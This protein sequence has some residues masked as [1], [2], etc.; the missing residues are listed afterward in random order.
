MP[1]L[2]ETFKAPA[3]TPKTGLS[4]LLEA[5]ITSRFWP[6]RLCLHRNLSI[7]VSNHQNCLDCGASRRYSFLTDFEHADAGI[8]IGPW[9]RAAYFY[10]AQDA[11]RVVASNLIDDAI[12]TSRMLAAQ[13]QAVTR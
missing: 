11:H 7:P 12:A 3:E 5:A 2:S 6:T 8:D 1:T 13:K 4:R 9:Q 10:L